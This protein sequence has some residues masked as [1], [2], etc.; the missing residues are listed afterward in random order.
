MGLVLSLFYFTWGN[1]I[2]NI[3]R[4]WANI[5]VIHPCLYR[6]C[7]NEYLVQRK[8]NFLSSATTVPTVNTVCIRLGEVEGEDWDSVHTTC[9]NTQCLY[10]LYLHIVYSPTVL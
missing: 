5:P 8:R 4:Q 10:T 6:E 9:K 7:L 1:T 2:I 3:I